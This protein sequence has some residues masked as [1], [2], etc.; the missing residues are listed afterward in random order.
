MLRDLALTQIIWCQKSDVCSS[1]GLF[2]QAVTSPVDLTT[3]SAI[4]LETLSVHHLY[5]IEW[6]ES[7]VLEFYLTTFGQRSG[8]QSSLVQIE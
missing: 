7:R 6:H 4:S 3:A 2:L 5:D 8:T 1:Y